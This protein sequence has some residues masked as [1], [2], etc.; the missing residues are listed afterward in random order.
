MAF[1]L[2]SVPMLGGCGN[3]FISWQEEVK[4]LDGRVIAV[5]QQRC[6][7]QGMEREAWLTISL[8]EFS[9]SAIVW[10]ENLDVTVLNVYQGNLYVVAIPGTIVEYRKYGRPEPPYIGYRF[11]SGHWV[12]VPFGEIP[13]AIYDANMYPQNMALARLKK[14]SISDKVEIFKDDRWRAH[15]RR[16]DPNYKSRLSNL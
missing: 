3:D 2:A 1:V 12:R 6:A 16:I 13:V 9:D 15:Q 5:T 4:L 11:D 8:P 7:E 14:V 10:H